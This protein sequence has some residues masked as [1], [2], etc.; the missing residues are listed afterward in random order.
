MYIT[1]SARDCRMLVRTALVHSG[2]QK[3][4]DTNAASCGG[5]KCKGETDIPV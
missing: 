5:I 3:P 2:W 1:Q 4:L